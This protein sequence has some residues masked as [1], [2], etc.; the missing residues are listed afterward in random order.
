MSAPVDAGTDFTFKI[1][2]KDKNGEGL[3]ELDRIQV[4]GAT[5]S[6]KNANGAT[7]KVSLATGEKE[8]KI[9][10]TGIP[11]GAQITITENGKS[12]WSQ[13][14]PPKDGK[15]LLTIS[16]NASENAVTITNSYSASGSWTPDVTKKLVADGRTLK[17]KEFNFVIKD[18]AGSTV[19]TGT[20][21]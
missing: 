9:T 15:Y 17:D 19:M 18:Q 12:G 13:V 8:K 16:E 20:N 7:V 21:E 10:F 11:V 3:K 5:V 4:T 1:A 2:W 14:K 6:K